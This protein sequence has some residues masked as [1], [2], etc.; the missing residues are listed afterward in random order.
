MIQILRTVLI[1]V[2]IA[3]GKRILD[4]IEDELK[5]KRRPKKGAHHE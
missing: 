5:R 3:T 1:E 2:I 4:A